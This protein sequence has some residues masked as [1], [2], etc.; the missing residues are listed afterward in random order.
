MHPWE[1]FQN[2]AMLK[3]LHWNRFLILNSAWVL[4]NGN[5]RGGNLFQI[6]RGFLLY[7]SSFTCPLFFSRTCT[8]IAKMYS[9]KIRSVLMQKARYGFDIIIC[10]SSISYRVLLRRNPLPSLP[11]CH[12]K[13]EV[14][15]ARF[16]FITELKG[17]KMSM[18][19]SV[20]TRKTSTWTGKVCSFH[21]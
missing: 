18:N 19:G 3:V 12:S 8:L 13:K 21:F 2:P 11:N 15:S 20:E 1:I 7:P 4:D 17:W 10:L 6:G 9:P 16:L 14:W 5:N